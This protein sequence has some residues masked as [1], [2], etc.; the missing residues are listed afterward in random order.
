MPCKTCFDGTVTIV[1]MGELSVPPGGR[2]KGG[3]GQDEDFA[4]HYGVRPGGVY[5]GML[6]GTKGM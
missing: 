5:D 6:K 1:L 4:K 3:T 2:R